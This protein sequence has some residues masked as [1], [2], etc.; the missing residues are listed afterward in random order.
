MAEGSFEE[1]FKLKSKKEFAV[2]PLSLTGYLIDRKFPSEDIRAYRSMARMCPAV[3]SEVQRDDI[4]AED[5]A[6]Q[7]SK[8]AKV[9]VSIA[10]SLFKRMSARPE[11]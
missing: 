9:D 4:S 1:I 6:S 3:V 8:Q 10:G 5:A 7:A 11:V 2:N